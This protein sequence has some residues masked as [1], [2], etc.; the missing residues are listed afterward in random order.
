MC[1]SQL[2]RLVFVQKIF[3]DLFEPF[4]FI[5]LSVVVVVIV[6]AA[7]ALLGML[8]EKRGGGG[9][10]K[11]RSMVCKVPTY[12]TSLFTKNSCRKFKTFD[13]EVKL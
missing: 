5:C 1:H 4:W 10:P 11:G 7:V 2:V 3:F 12:R 6:V 13:S 8:S 9:R